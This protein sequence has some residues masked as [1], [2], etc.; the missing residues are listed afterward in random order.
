MRDSSEKNI[1]ESRVKTLNTT[2]SKRRKPQD[3]KR[4]SNNPIKMASFLKNTSLKDNRENY[5]KNCAIKLR[6]ILN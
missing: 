3:W 1:L 4:K 5:P 2:E 6:V